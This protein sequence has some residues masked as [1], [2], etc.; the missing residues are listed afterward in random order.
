VRQ[1]VG[2]P[3][4]RVVVVGAADEPRLVRRR[5]QVDAAGQQGVEER[6]VGGQV[7]PGRRR[8]VDDAWSLKKTLNRLPAVLT[9]CGTPPRTAP[10]RPGRRA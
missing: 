1:G 4:E 7:L 5:R 2:D 10:P 8:V 9:R 6:L 3:V